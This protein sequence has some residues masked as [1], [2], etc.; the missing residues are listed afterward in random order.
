MREF[1][2]DANFSLEYKFDGLNLVV[3]YNN[4][5]FVSATTR[6]NGL[7][8]ED[9]SLQVKTIK[10]VPLKINFKGRLIV[11]GEGMMTQKAFKK[12]SAWSL[13]ILPH[14]SDAVGLTGDPDTKNYFLIQVIWYN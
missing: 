2:Q 11:Q 10:S 14:N 8:G 1:L 6:G 7:I 4:G 12:I 3:E 5:E 9:V 13:S